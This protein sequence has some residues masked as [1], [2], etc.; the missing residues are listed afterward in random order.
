MI[1]FYQT[2]LSIKVSFFC[3]RHVVAKLGLKMTDDQ[4]TDMIKVSGEVMA[5]MKMLS[6]C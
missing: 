5:V 4:I 2:S 6:G 3:F 1:C